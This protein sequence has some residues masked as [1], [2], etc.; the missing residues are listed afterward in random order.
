MRR[1]SGDHAGC[2]LFDRSL[3]TSAAGPPA[4]GIRKTWKNPS[5]A[6][7]MKATSRPSGETASPG[8]SCSEANRCTRCSS[9]PS[10]AR[11]TI[12]WRPGPSLATTATCRAVRHPFGVAH[13][14]IHAADGELDGLS[15][16]RAAL[17]IDAR[18]EH[19]RSM[20]RP[21]RSVEQ[22]P[23][24]VGR[25]AR[26]ADFGAAPEKADAPRRRIAH[27]GT[28]PHVVGLILVRVKGDPLAVGRPAERLVLRYR[29]VHDR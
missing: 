1:P 15:S 26:P 23:S 22:E 2:V 8:A 6:G 11:V 17:L 28:Q 18:D 13:L 5:A 25:P 24:S 16:D 21:A 20:R 12:T 10:R 4:S 29:R 3:V 19:H 9:P 27:R 7:A 14:G